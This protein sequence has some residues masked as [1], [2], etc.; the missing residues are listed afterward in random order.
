[1]EVLQI[2]RVVPDL[3]NVSTIEGLCANLELDDEDRVIKQQHSVD[4]LAESWNHK[5]KVY[6]SPATIRRQR[7][8][9]DADFCE[10]S[11]TLR[12]VN[13]ELPYSRH[14]PKN[15]IDWVTEEHLNRRSVVGPVEANLRRLLLHD[16]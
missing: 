16:N 15:E 1:M 12:D 5:F 2:E 9:K 14:S 13:R 7:L 10:P 4:P 11:I 8:T 3:V 6:P